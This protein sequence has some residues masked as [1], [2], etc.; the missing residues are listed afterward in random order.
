[1]DAIV[2]NIIHFSAELY[3]GKHNVCGNSHYYAHDFEKCEF[4]EKK[5]CFN[6]LMIDVA[7]NDPKEAAAL[8]GEW[9]RMGFDIMLCSL[10]D[11]GIITTEEVY[12]RW[13]TEERKEL[14]ENISRM[15]CTEMYESYKK[16]QRELSG[17][18]YIIFYCATHHFMDPPTSLLCVERGRE[19]ILTKP[20]VVQLKAGIS[21][22]PEC[23]RNGEQTISM[24]PQIL[25]LDTGIS[26]LSSYAKHG[27]SN[28]SAVLC[29]VQLKMG[30][31]K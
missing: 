28:I 7:Q 17:M 3:R 15:G 1:M 14:V 12:E 6:N 4:S 30:I 11:N 31:L 19:V 13:R 9:K 24:K 5:C 22:L 2:T 20:Y 27:T 21:N 8:C 29:A 26:K 18:Q 10:I 25:Q 23:A 16:R